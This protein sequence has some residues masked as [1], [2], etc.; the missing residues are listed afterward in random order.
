MVYVNVDEIY[1]R[2]MVDK[3]EEL[4]KKIEMLEEVITEEWELTDAAKKRLE[5]ARKTDEKKYIPL[6]QI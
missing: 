2:Q 5:Q 4:N 3:L 1:L 6:D